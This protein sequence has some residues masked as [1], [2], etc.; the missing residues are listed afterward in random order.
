[1]SQFKLNSSVSLA[2][3]LDKTDFLLQTKQRHNKT[4]KRSKLSYKSIPIAR[5]TYGIKGLKIK[6]KETS[7][8]SA[9]GVSGLALSHT[10]GV[11]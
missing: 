9:D 7:Q 5:I 2:M 1:M 10:S 8:Q 3:F 11:R 6:S 4:V